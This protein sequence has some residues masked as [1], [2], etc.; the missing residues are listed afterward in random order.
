MPDASVMARETFTL[1]GIDLELHE[2]G[3]G[4]PL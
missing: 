1:A 4:P 2:G 3:E